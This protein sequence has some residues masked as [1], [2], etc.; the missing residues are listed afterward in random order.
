MSL[1]KIVLYCRYSKHI[2]RHAY[3]TVCKYP[4][5]FSIVY[6]VYVHSLNTYYP[7]AIGYIYTVTT[8]VEFGCETW[9]EMHKSHMKMHLHYE[10]IGTQHTPVIS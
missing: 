6:L 8:Y 1:E 2:G 7:I 3:V 10:K 9:S 4:F 5:L